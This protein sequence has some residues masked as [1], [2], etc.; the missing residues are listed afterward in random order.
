MTGTPDLPALRAR[1]QGGDGPRF[2]RSLDAVADS[3]EFRAYLAVEFPAASR[4]AAQPGRRGF[5]KLMAASFALGGLTACG[6]DGRDYEVPYVNEPE[7]IVPGAPLSYASSALFDGFGNGILV[8][9]RNGRPL[10][11]EG[12]PDHPWSRGGTDVLAQASILGLYDP[13]R[14]QAV[15]HLGRPAS[16]AAFNGAMAAQT[17]AWRA[18]S[19][20]GV[21]LLTGP[22]TSPTLAAGLARWREAYPE[23]RWF[24][25][26]T[27]DGLLEGARRAYGRPVETLPDFG[28]AR[29]IVSLDG[30]FLD[31]GPGQVGLS[32]RWS[33]AR[34]AALAEGRLLPLYSAAPTPGLTSAKADDAVPVPAG[35]LE[36]L[37]RAMLA[38]AGGG[39]APAGDDPAGRWAGRAWAAL[40]QARGAGIVTA[41]LAASPD[42]HAL[43]HRLNGALG[44]TGATLHH[45]APAAEAGAGSLADLAGA[46]DRGEVQALIVLGANPV[47]DA[48]GALRFAAR[49]ERVP[50]K[51]HAGLYYDETG[52]HADWHLPLAHPLES[53]G[54]V[55][56]LDGT[57]GLIQPTVA[58]FYNGHTPP[59]VLAFLAGAD[60]GT[61]ALGLLKRRWRREGE[62]DAAF[63]GRFAEALRKGFFAD[64]AAPAEAVTLTGVPPTPP[65]PVPAPAGGIELAF[66]PDGT[67][68]DGTHAD[69]AWLQELPKPLIKVVWEN[70]VA[71]SPALAAREGLANGDL[72]R[73]EAEGRSLTGPAWILP[74]QAETTVTLSLGYGRDVPDHLSR[75]LGYDA[76]LLRPVDTPWHLAGAR[77][78]RTGETRMPATTQHL[79]ALPDDAE[80]RAIIRRQVVGAAPVGDPTDAAP[81]PSF[82]PP[83]DSQDRWTAAQWGM[84][85]DL[86][87]CTGC[88][89]C[90]TACQAEN[91]IPVVGREEVARGRWLGWIRIDRYYEG[92]PEA[93]ATHFQPVPCMH[94]EAAPCELGCP[95]EATLH[96]SEGLNLQV[97]NRCVGTRTC[98]SYCPYKVRRFNYLDYSGGMPPVTQQQRNPEVSVR[99][100]GVMEKCT[101]CIQRIATARIDSAKDAHA[102]IPDGTVETACQGACPTRAISFG[103]VADP[104]SEVSAAKRDPRNYSLLGHLNTKPRTTYLAGLAPAGR[105]GKRP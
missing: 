59:E 90:V 52:A 49:M 34:R 89:A 74:G 12:N 14:S 3:D 20:R 27:R 55:R 64:G 81:A 37:A 31:L 65:A 62:D 63:D 28:R 24:T 25:N 19:G 98:Q 85:I 58:P 42:L 97:Y 68:Y 77:L 40:G 56:S 95:V 92:D 21:A 2:W 72:V 88:N 53:W 69:L 8:T 51:I 39:A 29:A 1:L 48:P 46:I 17:A 96:D 16:W 80:G 33:D 44:N 26:S 100:R 38:A 91:N 57:V 22:V 60:E 101:Y 76:G 23:A 93:P 6:A 4:L 7:R 66:R 11:V 18:A 36:E 15:Q 87:T 30:D 102:P 5:L 86:D 10:K 71:V 75:G 79:G 104:Q 45:V 41:G 67:L 99:A 73:I 47:Y 35:R 61:D 83:P 94:C 9:T 13:F 84:A 43:V 105:E 32:R 78:V 50:L 54:D 70:V 82:Y 103:N